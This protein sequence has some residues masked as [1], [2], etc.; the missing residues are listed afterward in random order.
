MRTAKSC[1][2]TLR[3]TCE[4]ALATGMVSYKTCDGKEYHSTYSVQ[5]EDKHTE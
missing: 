1:A 2:Q 3:L 4:N 5:R